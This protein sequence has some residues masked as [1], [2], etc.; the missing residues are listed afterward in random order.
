MNLFFDLYNVFNSNTANSES[1]VVSQ[2][3]TVVNV[4]GNVDFGQKELFEGFQSP[5]VI[6][7]PR[8]FR[9]GARFSF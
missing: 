9:I 3:S 2:R 7:P 4:A 5:S 8:I 6:L 1:A